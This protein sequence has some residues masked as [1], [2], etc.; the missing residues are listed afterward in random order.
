MNDRQ[1]ISVNEAVERYANVVDAIKQLYDERDYMLAII[2]SEMQKNGAK[3]LA[4]PHYNVSIPT[5]RQYDVS[6]FLSVMGETLSP[7]DLNTVYSSAHEEQVIVP[8]KVNGT[9]AKKLWDMGDEMVTKLETTLIPQRPEI[10]V[11]RKKQE[12]PL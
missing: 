2:W 5:K 8:A 12:Q 11:E 1:D 7:E 6:K 4:H 9:K 3:V 10:K